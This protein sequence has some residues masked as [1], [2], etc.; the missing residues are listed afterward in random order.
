MGLLKVKPSEAEVYAI[1]RNIDDFPALVTDMNEE[2][3]GAWAPIAL[4]NGDASIKSGVGS[5]LEIAIVAVSKE[6]EDGD[7]TGEFKRVDDAASTACW[8]S[9]V[10]AVK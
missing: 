2:L 1:A 9:Y 6:D 7:D 4:K 8:V 5:E 10:V 3:S